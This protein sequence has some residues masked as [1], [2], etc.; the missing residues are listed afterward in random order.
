M[1][2]CLIIGIAPIFTYIIPHT[3]GLSIRNTSRNTVSSIGILLAL[4]A[5]SPDSWAPVDSG[6]KPDEV[7]FAVMGIIQVFAGVMIFTSFAPMMVNWV[8]QKSFLAK[9]I[10]PVAKV[11]LAYPAA[12]PVRTAVIMGMFSLTVFS[13]IVLAG[14]SVQ[15]EEH[16]SGYRGC[17]RGFRNPSILV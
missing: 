8:I 10:G 5:L 6:V 12:V 16:S 14:Y 2:S 11:A 17:K 1:A 15:F 9:K 7:T 13:V 3:R 4:W